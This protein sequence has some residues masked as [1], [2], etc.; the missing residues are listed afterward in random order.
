MYPASS[1]VE[2]KEHE[3]CLEGKHVIILF[4]LK[5]SD[6]G[7]TSYY[8]S[9]NYYHYLASGYCSIYLLGYSPTLDNSYDD[10]QEITSI[11]NNMWQYSDNCFIDLRKELNQRIKKWRY[12][13]EPEI[14]ILQKN[15]NDKSKDPL[16]FSHY[17]S[18]DINYGIKRGYIDSFPR[19]MERL[20]GACEKEVTA[21]DSIKKAEQ[22]RIIP[23]KIIEYTINACSNLPTPLKTIMSDKLFYKSSRG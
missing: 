14:V 7:A 23:K 10:I 3:N 8:K 20:I 19:F 6:E 13:G 22:K 5:P 9:L 1:L 11:N 21:I 16:D 15:S 4:L 17:I 12:S 2:I 18:I